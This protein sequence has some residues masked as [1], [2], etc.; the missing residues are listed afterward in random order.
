[1]SRWTQ[2]LLGTLRPDGSGANRWVA[3]ACVGGLLAVL[4]FLAGFSLL[5]E[6]DLAGRA[7]GAQRATRLGELYGDARFWVGQEES[8][9]RK[10]RLEP[11]PAVLQLH[12][13]AEANLTRDLDTIGRIDHSAGTQ[14]LVARLVREQGLYA[15]AS[16]EMFDAVEQHNTPLVVHYDHQIVDPVF[17]AIETTV[18]ARNAV[19]ARQALR[20]ADLL[21]DRTLSARAA[22]TI[23]FGAGLLLLGAFALILVGLRRRV[24]AAHRTE[25]ERLA[26]A[27]LT[28]SLT[29]LRNHRAFHEDLARD[30][31][32]QARVKEPLAL[33]MLD[34]NGL[35]TLNDTHGHQ[36]GDERLQV[37]AHALSETFRGG[38]CAYRVG[39]DEFAVIIPGV[40]AWD[41]LEATQRLQTT[42]APHAIDMTAGIADS[43]RPKDI[44]G[45]I[46]EA[47]LALIAGKRRGQ[48]VTL[49]SPELQP[50]LGGVDIDRDAEHISSLSTALA[51][52]VDAKDSYTRSHCQTVS[53]LCALIATE[54]EL[55]PERIAQMRLA[56]LLHDVGK[57]GIPDAIL[58]KPV[59]LTETE[60]EQMK[61]HSILGAEIVA[62]AGL[63]TEARWVRHHHE[64]YDG[65][66]YPDK[67]AGKNI[68]LQ[69]RI[70]LTADAFEAMTSDRPYRDAPGRDFAIAELKR[71]AGTQFDPRIVRA[72]CRALESTRHPVAD[73]RDQPSTHHA[74]APS[75]PLILA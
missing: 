37:L 15:R 68:P 41:A 1:M 17:G 45:L 51:L 49:Y 55:T 28:D 23:A 48:A 64:R 47:D 11:G 46:Q 66:G 34:L 72:F 22:I 3:R 58:T 75:A 43:S 42:L 35:K 9:E 60:Y 69:S 19:S 29:G 2:S 30:L 70:I 6:N 10:Y 7:A 63:S 20:Q 26:S 50:T 56:G 25:I 24:T 54:L 38:D 62:A 53:Q 27:A 65:N 12:S 67:L 71:H 61:R 57:I 52:A 33:I 5:T 18:Y 21:R 13:S 73:Q 36:A 8:L 39:G 16:D 44:D 4:C 40:G 14:Q 31:Q 59:A 32:R 74:P